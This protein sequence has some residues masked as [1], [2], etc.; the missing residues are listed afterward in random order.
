MLGWFRRYKQLK[1]EHAELT[2]TTEFQAQLID[3]LR[4]QVKAATGLSDTQ[5]DTINLLRKNR[6]ITE[7]TLDLVLTILATAVY[8]RRDPLDAIG[9]VFRAMTPKTCARVAKLIITGRSNKC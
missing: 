1:E 4:E 6:D 3:V 5:R 7:G 9:R 2:E 8:D